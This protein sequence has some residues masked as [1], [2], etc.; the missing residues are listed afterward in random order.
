[1]TELLQ[2][3]EQRPVGRPTFL[4]VLCILTFIGS[5]WG[6]IGSAIQYASAG[7][8][9]QSLSITKD[10]MS[11][12]IAKKDPDDKGAQFAEKMISSVSGSFTEKNIKNVAIA[13]ILGSLL[14][15]GG[16]FLMWGLK[17]TG[18]YLYVA[19]ILIGIIAPFVIFGTGNLMAVISSVGAGFIGIVFIILYGV[20][21]KHMR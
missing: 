7:V 11:K 5:G 14:C 2:E 20:N 9:A 12:D 13:S 15:L 3:Y 10:K 8:Q 16:A 18:F 21:L 4:T 17:K 1:M 6:V 19:G